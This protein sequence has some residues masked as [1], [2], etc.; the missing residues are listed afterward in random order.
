M[1]HLVENATALNPGQKVSIWAFSGGP[2]IAVSFLHRQTQVWKDTHVAWFAATSPVWGGVVEA[3][4]VYIS[5]VVA[6]I[7]PGVVLNTTMKLELEYLRGIARALPA[8]LWYFPRVAAN[9]TTGW[10]KDEPVVTTKSKTYTAVDTVE[11]LTDLGL[12]AATIAGLEALTAEPD[13]GAFA[14]P[15]VNTVVTFGTGFP[16]PVAL[17]YIDDLT[18]GGLTLPTRITNETGDN[19]VPRRSS[20]RSLQWGAA[21]R[22]AGKQLIHREYPGQPHAQCFPNSFVG[23]DGK[24]GGADG[25]ECFRSVIATINSVSLPSLAQV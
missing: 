23:G 8:A 12:D 16:V 11:I 3:L 19:L 17:E 9:S 4:A 20:L 2:Q 24:G 10:L 15:G 5:G 13:L 1:R 7:P 14:A 25:A 21:Q 22:A 6:A 18:R